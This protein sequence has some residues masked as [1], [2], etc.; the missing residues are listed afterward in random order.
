MN[1]KIGAV[2]GYDRIPKTYVQAKRM[3]SWY[4][5][6]EEPQIRVKVREGLLK[7]SQEGLKKRYQALESFAGEGTV[8]VL[9]NREKIEEAK[10]RF[11]SVTVLME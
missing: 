8:C 5:R 4:L 11:D 3:D 9:G 10:D 2:A 7:A 1:Y 6:R